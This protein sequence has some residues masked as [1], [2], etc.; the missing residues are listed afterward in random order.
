VE[1]SPMDTLM[2]LIQY[3]LKHIQYVTIKQ[4][5]LKSGKSIRVSK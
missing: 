4:A 5:R 3:N 1:H 2:D